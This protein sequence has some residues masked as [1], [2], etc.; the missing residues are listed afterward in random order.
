MQ[1][2]EILRVY[3]ETQIELLEKCLEKKLITKGR[4]RY[5]MGEISGIDKILLRIKKIE[6]GEVNGNT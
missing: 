3:C 5:L 4:R 1:N 2:I 6:D